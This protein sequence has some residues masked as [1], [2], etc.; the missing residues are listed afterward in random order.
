MSKEISVEEAFDAALSIASSKSIGGS[1]QGRLKNA[2]RLD[3]GWAGVCFLLK[4]GD[5]EVLQR[6]SRREIEIEIFGSSK[7]SFTFADLSQIVENYYFPAWKQS[8]RYAGRATRKQFWMFYLINTICMLLLSPIPFLFWVYL[9]CT[10]FPS[11]S[12]LV[13]R[14]QDTRRHWA[15]SFL[16]LIPF[17]GAVILVKWLAEPSKAIN[18]SSRQSIQIKSK[19]TQR[20]ELDRVSQMFNDGV[21]TDQEYQAMRKKIL[22]I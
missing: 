22:D 12:I 21:I 7:M 11:S 2:S 15:L 13:R 4:G 5:G 8:F 1:Q 19:E 3:S 10:C 9:F 17:F 14:L 18:Q 16:A 20:E 6:V